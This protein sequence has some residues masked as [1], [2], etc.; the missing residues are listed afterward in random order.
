MQII[1]QGHG[2]E[3]TAA[4]RDYALKKMSKLE[5]YFNNIQ[6]VDVVLDARAID[7]QTRNQVAEV[8]VWA[9]GKRKIRAS[10]AG[11]DM[12]A[13]ID[14]VSEEVER[15]LRKHKDKM[16]K[17]TRRKSKQMKEEMRKGVV[18]PAETGISIVNVDRFA[19][20]PMEPEDAKNELR[21][22]DQDFLLFRNPE[23]KSINLVFRKGENL[24]V[25][26]PEEQEIKS[27]SPEDAAEEIRKSGS[28]FMMF[29]NKET[30]NI[31]VL[32][33]R[34]SGNYG[35]IEPRA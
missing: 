7:D 13:A 30:N 8:T 11:Q 15:Q 29:K 5:Q 12:Y 17:E 6:K 24:S 27:I 10:E 21:T 23:T 33:R 16:V 4:M 28:D 14:L 20:K 35:L 25:I 26:E 32:Y 34:H 18:P 22:M 9:A 1:V 2:T 19:T 31:S 3:I